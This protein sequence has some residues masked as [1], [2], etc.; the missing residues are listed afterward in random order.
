MKNLFFIARQNLKKKKGDFFVL[1]FLITLATLLFYTSISVFLGM[2]TVVDEVYDKTHTPDFFYMS[3]AEPEKIEEIITAQEEVVEYETSDCVFLGDVDYGKVEQKEKNQSPFIFG[4]IEE[5]RK[6]GKLSDVENLEISYQSIILPYYMK[7]GE[8]FE[9]GD[10]CVFVLGGK[11]YEFEIAGFTEDAMFANPMNVNVYVVY[12]SSEHMEDLLQENTMMA[13]SQFVQHKVRLKEG[14]SGMEFEDRLLP[15]LQQEIPDLSK[16]SNL[17]LNWEVMKGGVGMMSSISM[18]IFLIFSL[19]LM[20]VVLI[21]VRFSI[22]NYIELN[23]K[24]VGI[25]QAAGYTARQLRMTVMLEMGMITVLAI[26]AGIILG[27]AGSGVIGTFQ[28]VM[29]G[30]KWNQ[31]F[32]MGAAIITGIVILGAVLGV[33]FLCSRV[34]KK[35]SVLESLR[36]GIR[37]HN[38]KKNYFRMDKSRASLPFI[39]AGKNLFH[40]KAKNISIFCIVMLLSF[41]AS[42]GFSIY[43]NFVRSDNN[44]LKMIG[45]ETGDIIISGENLLQVK[46]KVEKWPEVEKI[47]EMD[48]INVELESKAAETTV[49]CDVWDNPELLENEMMVRGRLPRYENEIVLT[50]NVAKHLKVDVGDTIYVTGQGEKK[51][52]LIC[53][54]DQK[55]NNMGMKTMLHKNGAERLNGTS[56]AFYLY[57]YQKGDVTYKELSEKILNAFPN[58][59]V[60]DSERVIGTTL[61]IVDIAVVAICLIFVIITVL[62]VIMVEVLLIKSKVIRERKNLGLNKAFGFTTRQLVIQTA[63]INLPVIT[64]GAVAGTILSIF[65]MEPLMIMCFSFC[66][67]EKFLMTINVSWLVITI[68]GIILVAAVTSVLSAVKIRKIQPIKMLQEE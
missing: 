57:A 35:I 56:R 40:E 60:M 32:H 30:L 14:A 53:G 13:T 41:A 25:L 10:K 19:L 44:L 54:V 67:L 8:G 33:A 18:G 29:M 21:I 31:V 47:L 62:V 4:A 27:V 42:V 65:L 5:E 24:N 11:E 43:E 68:V 1:F 52:Y 46:E 7:M 3:N 51:D 15:L 64:A 16:S 61:N 2:D 6:I 50:A 9:A 63:M 12:I 49:A 36:N 55:I 39:L 37:T 59:S 22:R 58:L 38:F 26:V 17:G 23:L 48:N 66:G 34:Y 20:L 45:S 28:G